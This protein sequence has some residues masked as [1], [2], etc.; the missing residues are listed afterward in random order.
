[1]FQD[2]VN[3][4]PSN[5]TL[6]HPLFVGVTEYKRVWDIG[7][8][9]AIFAFRNTTRVFGVCPSACSTILLFFYMF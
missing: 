6:T 3:G 2:V 8:R 1:M 4:H 9:F 5:T 7:L